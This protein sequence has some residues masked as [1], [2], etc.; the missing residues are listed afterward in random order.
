MTHCRL[1]DCYQCGKCTAGCPMAFAMDV[2]PNEV[3]RLGQMGDAQALLNSNTIW[4]CVSCQT[5]SAR[6]PQK[7]KI[8]ETIDALREYALKKGIRNPLSKNTVAFHRVFLDLVKSNGRLSETFLVM[9][10][11]M[12]TLRFTDDMILG[13]KMALKGKLKTGSEKIK[14]ADAVKKIFEKCGM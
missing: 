13:I 6:C 10:Y 4:L 8:A 5:C 3:I 12:K 7:V 14:G 2:M 11:K 1:A 9:L